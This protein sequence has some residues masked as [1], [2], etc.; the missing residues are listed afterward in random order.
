MTSV[1]RSVA[2][3]IRDSGHARGNAPMRPGVFSD[4]NKIRRPKAT[5]ATQPIASNEVVRIRLVVWR[6]ENPLRFL[7]QGSFQGIGK[8][9][10]CGSSREVPPRRRRI[11]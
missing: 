7:K 10:G 9:G 3:T 2:G 11:I 5:T 6:K 4:W 8:Y 1:G